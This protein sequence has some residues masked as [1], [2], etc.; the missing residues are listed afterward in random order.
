ME[1]DLAGFSKNGG[2]PDL[3][4]PKSGTNLFMKLRKQIF[5]RGGGNI[6][7]SIYSYIRL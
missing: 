5:E 1:P 6:S 4:E 7:Q 3:P 2:I